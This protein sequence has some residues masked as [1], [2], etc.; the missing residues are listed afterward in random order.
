MKATAVLK[1]R[2]AIISVAYLAFSSFA[3]DATIVKVMG[4][5]VGTDKVEALKDAYR[6]AVE[7][8]VGLYVDAEQMMKN[9][10][11]VK[12]QILTHSNAYIEKYDVVGETVAPNGLVTVKILA[13]VKTQELAKK[14]SGSMPSITT[15][16]NTTMLKGFHAKVTTQGRRS[17]D[18]KALLDNALKDL[19]PVR[20]LVR[21]S[22]ASTKPKIFNHKSNDNVV[23][24]CYLLRFE[25][26]RDLYKNEYMPCLQRVL[27]QVS[28]SKPKIVRLTKKSASSDKQKDKALMDGE[29]IGRAYGSISGSLSNDKRTFLACLDS[30]EEQLLPRDINGGKHVVLATEF[31]D[32]LSRCKAEV[33]SI[34]DAAAKSLSQWA[35][36]FLGKTGQASFNLIFNDD[37]QNE[38]CTSSVV[39]ETKNIINGPFSIGG[40]YCCIMPLMREEPPRF[41][42][43]LSSDWPPKPGFTTAYYK[44][45]LCEID[46]DDL[47]KIA[48]V[49]IEAAE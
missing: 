24:L 19:D 25:L 11:L 4:R 17:E 7:R 3:Q 23:F 20:Q 34:D 13:E 9:E 49:T 39:V 18:G 6:D 10:E 47:P 36:S 45:A 37:S 29:G 1:V 35:S 26:D 32:N 43:A 12:D 33:Y 44:W 5:G 31:S 16:L 48:S 2:F 46:K 41:A 28:T 42:S 27:A 40:D 14:V 30:E 8:A 21:V 38:V 22:L 15:K